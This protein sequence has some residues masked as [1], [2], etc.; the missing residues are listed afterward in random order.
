MT[1]L[2]AGA[3]AIDITPNRSLHL[4]GYPHVARWSTGVHDPLLA[5]ALYLEGGG[6]AVLFVACDIIF[7]PKALAARARERIATATGIEAQRMIIGA[8]HT[9]SGPDTVRYASNQADP[10]VPDP[11]ADYLR[12][13]EDGI[14]EAG[15]AAFAKRRPAETGLAC[16]DGSCAGTNRRSPQGP[17]QPCVPVLS[18]RARET[19][20]PIAVM[21]V[22]SMHPTVLHED[23]TLISGDFPGMTRQYL[24]QH[25]V[26]ADCPVLHFTGAAGNQSPRHVVTGTTFEEAERLGR[27]L[28]QSVAAALDRI[29]HTPD[30]GI[31]LL[32]CELGLPLR[33]FPPENLAATALERARER[34]VSLKQSNA[35]AAEI[36]T[37]ECDVFGA[38]EVLTLAHA[39]KHG[40]LRAFAETCLPAEVQCVAIGPWRFVAFPG[41]LF[42]E[43]ALDIQQAHPQA[44]VITFANGELQGYLVTAEAVREGGYEASNAL[45]KSPESGELLVKAALDL[46]EEMNDHQPT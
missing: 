14:V 1:T 16:A 44:H 37:A 34:F 9:H 6:G 30:A 27:L 33:T 35:P 29:S 10:T 12:Q 31:A 39:A 26:S 41:E 18:V 3:H 42:V 19:G 8:T 43:F 32:Q 24:Q 40:E 20:M 15:C 36:R 5:S 2:H 46:L 4:F 45:F 25:V 21:L 13:L 28:G 11:D 38:E 7:I 17:A 23:S 22:C